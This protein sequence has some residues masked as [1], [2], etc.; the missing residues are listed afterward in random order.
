MPA[1][2]A[3]LFTFAG[4]LL[5]L[6]PIYLLASVIDA[7]AAGDGKSGVLKV[8]VW[9]IAACVGTAV[10]A[11]LAEALTGVTIARLVAKLRERAVAAVLNLPPTTVESLG[12]GEVLGRVG[13]DVAALVSSARK[14]VP[15]TLSALVM[16]VVASAGIGGLDWRLALAGLCGIPFYALG[17]RW[18]LPR[19]APLYRRQRELEAGVIG[20]LQG[21]MEGIRSVRSHRL[22]ESRQSLTRRYAQASRDESIAAFR[23]FSGLVARENF[24]EFVGLS[25][26]SIVGWLLFREDL[27]SVGEISA[28]LILFHRQFVPIGTI[29][30]TFDELQRSGA[31]LGRIVGL[32]HSV[33]AHTPQPIESHSTLREFPSVEVDGL[34]YQY[35]NGP[36]ILHDLSFQIPAGRSVCVVG[37]SGAGKSTVAGIVSGTLE[38]TEPGVITIDGRDVVE[39][40]ARERSSLFCVASQE[41]YV[42]AMSLRDNL[43]L[44]AESAS[45]AEIW[46]ALRRIGAEDW[47]TS[48]SHG[49]KH[50]LD[51]MLGEGGLHVDAVAAQRLALARVAL[52][53]AG[54]VILD[55][56]TAE[57]DGYFEETQQPNEAFSMSLENAARAAIRGRTAMVIAHRLSQ[58]TTADSVV[59]MERGRVVE[60]GSHK[61]LAASGGTYADMWTAWNE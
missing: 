23:V 49:S 22:V 32:I 40:S 2:S 43:L 38:I 42:F 52:S 6:V 30:F 20:S 17:L 33:G 19:S 12:R 27:V 9:A 29:L 15:S 14:S 51:T 31:A 45:D 48:L 55:E 3:M 41:N 35:E 18:Y 16:V 47:C 24:A 4:A 36:K 44:A 11:G 25:A 46:D 39:M 21:S 56:S 58:A 34:N 57:D 8:I 60:T 1:V 10:V 13:A 28:A 26:L 61:E 59:V 50:G 37:G 53:R 54:V 7:V 5:S